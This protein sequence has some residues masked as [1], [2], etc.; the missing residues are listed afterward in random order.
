MTTA[1]TL[2]TMVG[3]MMAAAL[4]TPKQNPN[5]CNMFDDVDLCRVAH[6]LA[7]VRTRFE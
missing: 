7:A 2:L 5:G 6:D 4:R 1:L 3:I